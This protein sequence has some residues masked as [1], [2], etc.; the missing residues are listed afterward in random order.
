MI[1]HEQRK[2]A[3]ADAL[4]DALR[5]GGF[6]NVTLSSV[7]G[8]AGLA[9]GSVRHFLGARE[10][11]VGFAFDTMAERIRHRVTI[12]ADSILSSLSDGSSDTHDRLQATADILC[13]FL[14]LDA[15]RRDE[16]I[17]WI[18]F[19]TAARTSTY[20]AE[21]SRQAATKTS[22]L[23]ETILDTA[24]QR[25]TLPA[26]IDLPAEATILTAIID[27][28]TFRS[29]LHP[30]IVTADRAR[31]AVLTHLRN[32]SRPRQQGDDI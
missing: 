20:L 17:V 15:A 6:E 8:R 1:D 2:T 7:A 3:I 32:L 4:F 12:R 29:A 9:I 21:T 31:E 27:G 11:M 10:Q 30:D 23:I 14:P 18:E 26:S 19:E 28:L 5:E 24:A 16:A 25:G 22:Q 13:E